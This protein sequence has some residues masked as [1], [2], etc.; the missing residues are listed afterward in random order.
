MKKLNSLEDLEIHSFIRD[1]GA[2]VT[3]DYDPDLA[4]FG[5]Y[6]SKIFTIMP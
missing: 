1:I 3:S 4:M 5:S 6:L 2:A